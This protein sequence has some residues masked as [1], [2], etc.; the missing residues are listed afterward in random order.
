MMPKYITDERIK[1]FGCV[2]IERL[3]KDKYAPLTPL[4]FPDY[5]DSN[6]SKTIE[7]IP[8][9]DI[10]FLLEEIKKLNRGCHPN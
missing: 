7:N 10:E 4:A 1:A 5:E 8:K 2:P 3:D 9:E 6:Y